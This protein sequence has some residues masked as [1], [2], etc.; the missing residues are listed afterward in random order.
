MI[1]TAGQVGI[2]SATGELAEGIEAQTRQTLENI[3]AILSKGGAAMD[4]V[5]KVTVHLQSFDDFDRFDGIYRTF[6]TEP[7]PARTTVQ[8]ELGGVLI[9]IDAIATL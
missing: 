2:D 8:S 9:E 5:V 4:D 7:R 3:K 1:F 6:F